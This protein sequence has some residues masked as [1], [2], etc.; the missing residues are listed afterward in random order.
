[1]NTW[2]NA[3]VDPTA[4]PIGDANATTD[5]VGVGYLYMCVPGDLERISHGGP[6]IN[7]DL[8]V[9]D[10][11]TKLTVQGEIEWE[12]DYNETVANAM[13]IIST[14]TVPVNDSTGI[15]P[16]TTDDPAYQYDPNRGTVTV[17]KR[18][19]T[20]PQFGTEAA[21]PGCLRKG[22]V[23]ILRNGVLMFG[24]FDARG[25]DAVAHEVQDICQGHP[26]QTEY[27]Y[28]SVSK[29]V[30]ERATG[31]STVVGFAFDGFPIVVERD[32]SGALPTNADLDECHGR[33]SPVLLDGEVV[34][35][36]HYSATLEFPYFM[37][38]YKGTQA[39]PNNNGTMTPDSSPMPAST[40]P[41]PLP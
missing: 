2:T 24:A 37:G 17:D 39:Y 33:T 5:T 31:P 21:E 28:H 20:L 22:A 34:T 25:E 36:Y 3:V 12:G 35:T 23:G 4:L 6:W 19:V 10:S 1:V 29:C 30:L 40:I 32:A 13:R 41:A 16:I 9:W 18:I 7:E 11:T 26:A 27:H 8:N 15:F 38:C 14:Y